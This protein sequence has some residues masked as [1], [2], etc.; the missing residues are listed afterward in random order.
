MK[1]KTEDIQYL[2]ETQNNWRGRECLNLIASENA[3]S[4]M[5]RSIESNDFMGRYAEGHPNTDSEDRR[6]YEGTRW[7][8]E[9]ERIAQEEIIELANCRQADVRPI[10]GNAANTALALGILRGGDSVIVNSIEQGGHI[11]HNPIGVVGR[12]IQKRGQVLTPGKDHSIDL[13][14]WPTTPDGYHLDADACVKLLEDKRP[15]LAILGKSLFLF[16]EPVK[17]IAEAC[18]NM[19]IPLLYDG[20]HVL[21]LILGGCFQDPLGEGAH[22]I[23]ASTHKTFPGPQRGVILGNL[24][25]DEEMKWWTS[26]DRGVMPGSSSSHHLHTLPGLVIAIRE[27]KVY[28]KAYAE[29]TISNA[30]ALGRALDEEGVDVEAKEFGFTESHQ[31][32][33][34]VTR[35]GEAKTIARQLAEQNI[36]CNYNQLPGDPDPRYPSG[37]RIGVQEMTRMGMKESEMGEIAQLMGDAMNGKDVLQQVGRL[38][39]Q[40]IEVQFC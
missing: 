16:P 12:R 26:I 22:F 21:G 29:Q 9:I 40:F 13:H 4:P 1:I 20:A 19:K 37:L 35:F 7:I 32:A 25:G 38:R 6:Y 23:N 31:L 28:G 18:R 30:K 11:S 2:V 17:E 8:D 24:E 36:I 15:N 10:S 3:Q 5:V 33:V 34:R 14:Y 39:E 27:M